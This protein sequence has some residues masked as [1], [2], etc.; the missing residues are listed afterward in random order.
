M[1]LWHSDFAAYCLSEMALLSL[2]CI[3]IAAL[4][5]KKKETKP[6]SCKNH[7]QAQTNCDHFLYKIEQMAI[8]NGKIRRGR[9]INS[10]VKELM[11]S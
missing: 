4:E 8:K 6:I 10:V 2:G 9:D 11:K 7:G 1:R 5:K 3:L